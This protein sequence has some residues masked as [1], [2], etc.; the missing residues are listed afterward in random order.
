MTETMLYTFI[1]PPDGFDLSGPLALGPNGVLY[2][3]TSNGGSGN[4][5]VFALAP[6]AQPGGSWTETTLHAFTGDD[7]AGPR[8]VTAGPDG[9]LYGTT[10]TG[11]AG[12]HG[13]VF[14][15]TP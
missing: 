12:G 8:G 11:G 9:T 2:G 14:A 3:T 5:T 10:V 7:G 1:G 4:G 6:P 13:T 15:L